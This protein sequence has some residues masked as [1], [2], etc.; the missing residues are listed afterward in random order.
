[1]KSLTVKKIKAANISVEELTHV[2]DVE[3]IEYNDISEVNWSEFNYRPSVKFRIAH[4]GKNIFLNFKVK[5]NSIRALHIE[6]NSPVS[7]DSCVEFFIIPSD[8][9]YYYNFE[10]NCIGTMLLCGRKERPAKE[11]ALP[12][13]A[14]KVERWSSLG[15]KPFDLQVGE[16]EWQLSVIIP[17]N[18]FFRSSPIVDLSG[19][20]AKANF[21][22]CGDLLQTK[23]YLSWNK[24]DA[25]KPN[26]HLPEYFGELIF[27]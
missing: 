7:T 12:H 22:K 9:E 11:S 26:F 3:D 27:E 5:E 2:F 4:N 16:F 23:H 24:I 25:P 21:Y 17:V 1:M 6:N 20:K 8:D 19:K 14:E 18:T 13:I 15:S 10:F